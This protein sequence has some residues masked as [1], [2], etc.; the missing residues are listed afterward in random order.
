MMDNDPGMMD[1]NPGVNDVTSDQVPMIRLR[2]AT[3]LYGTVIGANDLTVDVPT[4]AHALLGR[5][6]SGKTT[7]IN[8][9]TGGLRPT[10][11]TVEVFGLPAWRNPDV[12]RRIGLCPAADVLYPNVSAVEWVGYLARLS[13]LSPRQADAATGRTI[14]L[15]GLGERA[16]RQMGTYSLGMR[17][18]AKLAQ[19][20]VHDPDLLILDEPF[21][22]LDP[23]GRADMLRVLGRWSEIGNGRKGLLIASH[24][25]HEVEAVTDSFLLIHGARLMA[26]GRRDE[27]H[28]LIAG[29]PRR[30]NVAGE[31]L[32]PL[33]AM[34]TSRLDVRELRIN[35]AATTLEAYVTDPVAA[36]RMIAAAGGRT[37]DCTGEHRDADRA[38]EIRIDSLSDSGGDLET[39]FETLMR[40]QT[41]GSP[42]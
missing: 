32:R 20:L 29:G 42:V 36:C 39:L 18:R 24:V 40:I 1:S 21:N 5:N 41:G 13:G 3:K 25:L 31:N 9:L 4:G 17:Q 28:A 10:R 23:I 22:G 16:K 27:I 14:E 19:A 15:V 37:S 26:F 33:A 11:G 8:L 6:G 34:L 7:L 12:L 2:G 30:V 38:S 35:D